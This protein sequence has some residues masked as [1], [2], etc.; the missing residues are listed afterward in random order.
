MASPVNPDIYKLPTATSS[1]VVVALGK[2]NPPHIGHI[3]I[4]GK[5]VKS[6]S[7]TIQR[8]LGLPEPADTVIF[9]SDKTNTHIGLASKK[10]L[11][12]LMDKIRNGKIKRPHSHKK[13]G[14]G[15]TE[16]EFMGRII[17]DDV[18][19]RKYV[20]LEEEND[21]PLSPEFK[22][23][24]LRAIY[25]RNGIIPPQ[26][27]VLVK[28]GMTGLV[29]QIEKAGYTNMLMVC[30]SDRVEGYTKVLAEMLPKLAPSLNLLGVFSVGDNRGAKGVSGT[31]LRYL[32]NEAFD[33]L[34]VDEPL[35][36]NVIDT[37]SGGEF[38]ALTQY[39]DIAIDEATLEQFG[40]FV[41]KPMS[42]TAVTMWQI[43]HRIPRGGK[44][45]KNKRKST[46]NKRKS[47]KNKRKSRK[48]KT[49]RKRHYK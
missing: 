30:G 46:K 3:D 29:S 16:G 23:Y 38:K 32:A 13:Q 26:N 31:R 25:E 24:L 2:F 1:T 9:A 41:D 21:T 42:L 19:K 47:T 5:G 48:N 18:E 33:E 20:N 45:T 37:P 4:L 40:I 10:G 39:P 34:P 11:I 14:I 44:K 27:V 17:D 22:L 6:Y 7:E 43:R 15:M 35:P 8:K 12:D 36:G 28:K 49:K